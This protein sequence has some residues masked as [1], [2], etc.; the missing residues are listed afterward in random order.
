MILDR[1]FGR[2]LSAKYP[3]ISLG[4]PR[5]ADWLN[6]GAKSSAGARVDPVHALSLSS[7]FSAC[8]LLSRI[9]GSLPLPI[10]RMR[11]DGGKDVA[12]DLRGFGLLNWQPNPEMTAT[13]FKR[14]MEWHRLLFGHACAEIQ[15][16]GDG[17]PA[18]A[19]L[20]EGWR[21]RPMRRP[22]KSL[23]YLVDG[24]REVEPRDLIYVPAVSWNGVWGQSFI[25]YAIESLGLGITAQE[26]A[27][28]FFG[29]GARPGGI[30]KHPGNP[31]PEA[32][33]EMRRSWQEN[34]GG[35]ERAHGTGVIWGGWEY[36]RDGGSLSPQETQLLETRRF[37]TEEVS[38]WTGIPPHMLSDLS[39]ATFSNIEEMGT[40][41]VTYC[42]RPIC[43]DYEQE[44]DRKMFDPPNVF[45]RH[46]FME[47]TR[48]NTLARVAYYSGLF[49]IGALSDNEIRHAEDMNPIGPD[50]DR[51]FVP[52]NMVPIDK[53]GQLPQEQKP[54]IG[55]PQGAAAKHLLH[56][57][58]ER[59][60]RVETNAI[61]RASSKPNE[62]LKWLDEFYPEHEAKLYAAVQ[63]V[64]A[65]IAPSVDAR[66]FAKSQCEQSKRELLELAGQ[67]R[68]A[69][70]ELGVT[71]RMGTWE[72]SII[73]AWDKLLESKNA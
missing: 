61:R 58:V 4:D 17:Q 32:R 73:S 71:A 66:K 56:S 52:L 53:A 22:D 23:Y 10:Y 48:G 3:G 47:L 28:R 68:A 19:W 31:K 27:A 29:N 39:R 36:V 49:N 9:I 72:Q 55:G 21:V 65:L 35:A 70:F 44:Y 62:F 30:L 6:P 34:H 12:D 26:F 67:L 51:R 64:L 42:V 57:T 13:T 46:D 1:L 33:A 8:S 38:R 60:C 54:V 41:L 63:P 59:M 15:W 7:I 18:Y 5:I 25:D 40:N 11:S 16:A 2:Q 20:I 45:S 69:D 37:T 14:M 24:Q 50:G 43:V